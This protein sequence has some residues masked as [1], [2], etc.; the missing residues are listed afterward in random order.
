[1]TA[2]LRIGILGCANIADSMIQAAAGTD[3]AVVQAVASRDAQK[4]AEWATSRGV[5]Q[6]FGSY[7]DLLTSGSI[8]AVYIPLPNS[9]H[10]QWSIAALKAGLPVLC[11]K[12]LCTTAEDALQVV[13]AAREADLPLLEGYMYRYH[14]Q[15]AVVQELIRQ[16]A[17]GELSSMESCFSW[18][19]D[20]RSEIPA[21][22]EL[23]GGALRDV[24]GYCL[25]VS[26]MIA[27]CEPARVSA[28]ERR[29]TVDDTMLG[30]LE[31]PTGVLARFETSIAN[32]ERHRVE[33]T[34]TAGSIVLEHPW[35]PGSKP[36]SII[37][38]REEQ[39]PQTI[40]VPPANAYTLQLEHFVHLV[41]SGGVDEAALQD[42]LAMAE[43][44]DALYASAA[45]GRAQTVKTL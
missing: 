7:D 28:F 20:D 35:V 3:T 4:A 22:N 13:L 2:P 44:M 12:P 15:Y 16:G 19:C 6:S 9:L 43:V 17:I 36:A 45:D 29:S 38:H 40:E 18:M 30:L 33:I 23:G 26:R 37:L 11:E 42:A 41:R 31:F 5:P 39:P 14:P 24:G 1:M 10:A 34:G 32:Y 8:D 21:S 25:H 27:A